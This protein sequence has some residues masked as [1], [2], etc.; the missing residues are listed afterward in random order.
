VIEQQQAALELPLAGLQQAELAF[1]RRSAELEYVFKHATV[2]EVAYGMLVRKRRRELHLR[3]ARSIASLYPVDE[4]VEIIAYHYARTDEPE[5]AEWLERAGDRA[6]AIYASETALFHYREAIRRLKMSAAPGESITTAPA[7]ARIAE[8]EGGVLATAGQYDEALTELDRAVQLYRQEGDHEGMGRVTARMGMAHRY[9][10]TPEEGIALVQPI[11]D[12][13]AGS[14]PTPACAS[15]HLALANL[16]FL[17]GRYREQQEE[18]EG[19]A[20]IARVIGDMRLLGEAEERRGTA[21]INLGQSEESLCAIEGAIPLIE[22]GGD[23]DVLRRA[24]GNAG[25]ACNSLGQMEVMRAY[26]ERSLAVAE[27]VG[28]PDQIAFALGSLG[29]TLRLLGDWPAARMHL[30]R[31]VALVGDRRTAPTSNPLRSL[32]WLALREGKWDEAQHLLAEALAIC[33]QTNDRWGR[34]VSQEG[35][36][37]LDIAMG[38]PNEAIRRLEASAMEED[39]VPELYPTLAW[40]YLEACETDRAASLIGEAVERARTAGDTYDLRWALQVQG[41][42]LVRQHHWAEAEM[43]LTEALKIARARMDPNNEAR[44]L[45]QLGMMLIGRGDIEEAQTLLE[46]ALAIFRRLGA[47][48]DI[49]RTEEALQQLA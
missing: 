22:A 49:E 18:A 11:V 6:A 33:E 14:D 37:E 27:R 13:L 15:L 16:Y 4:Y 30:E 29:D 25:V 1:P 12:L 44:A 26:L 3:V 19:G 35:L 34:E 5:A 39:A 9:R 42:I 45:H 7:L 48:K 31:A 40:A 46:E 17:V 23:L 24:L 20:A 32:G 28:N 2:Q 43:A 36:A 10:G 41:M 38:R 47:T 21:L 8:K